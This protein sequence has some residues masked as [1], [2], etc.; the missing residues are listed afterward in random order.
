[1]SSIESAMHMI[2]SGC[3]IFHATTVIRP[4]FRLIWK[5]YYTV[6][7][8]AYAYSFQSGMKN[9]SDFSTFE[10]NFILILKEGV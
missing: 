8:S 2:K 9:L 6:A 4:I 5:T 3:K 7:N 10:P 1:M